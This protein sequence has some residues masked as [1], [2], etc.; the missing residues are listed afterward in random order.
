M[1]KTGIFM[2]IISIVF[3]FFVNEY[4]RYD[5]YKDVEIPDV[6]IAKVLE[7]WYC[8]KTE[9]GLLYFANMPI[10]NK[11]CKVYFIQHSIQDYS[12][13]KNQLES[14]YFL[15][16]Y[17]LSNVFSIKKI[18][19]SPYGNCNVYSNGSRYQS[20]T[21]Y[22]NN[23]KVDSYYIDFVGGDKSTIFFIVDDS[24]DMKTMED[25]TKWFKKY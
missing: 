18:F 19:V 13:E 12:L 24:I 3:L 7:S 5:G 25:M 14:G 1:K 10:E 22:L 17:T 4:Y 8:S 2:I 11:G 15:S 23:I 21:F 9:D 16:D 6:G 20:C